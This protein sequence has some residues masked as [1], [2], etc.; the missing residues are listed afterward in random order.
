MNGDGAAAR[1]GGATRGFRDFVR[2]GHR[3]LG[4]LFGGPPPPRSAGAEPAMRAVLAAA[5]QRLRYDPA[6]GRRDFDDLER[7]VADAAGGPVTLN[8]ING[9]CVLVS[10]LRAGGFGADEVWVAL[11]GETSP[12]AASTGPEFHA[13]V[14]LLL[15]DGLLWIDPGKLEPVRSTGERVLERYR[16]YALFN[17]CYVHFLECEKRRLLCAA[18]CGARP[19]AYLFGLAA[20]VLVEALADPAFRALLQAMGS[21]AGADPTDLDDAAR[22]RLAAWIDAGLVA[23]VDGRL[24]PGRTVLLVPWEAEREVF[25]LT[26]CEIDRYLGIVTATLPALRRAFESSTTARRWSWEEVAHAVVAGMLMDLSVGREFRILNRVHAARGESV[27]WAFGNVSA[28]HGVGVAWAE[29]SSGDWGAGQLWHLAARRPAIRL[30]P[31]MVEVLGRLALGEPVARPSAELLY[32]RHRR[33]IG[34]Q[35]RG[36]EVRWPTFL[37]GDTRLLSAVLWAAGRRLLR[38]AILPAIDRLADHPWWCRQKSD[39]SYRHALL[40]LALDYGTDRVFDAGLLSPPPVGEPPPAWGR[41][42]WLGVRGDALPRR[43]DA[44]SASARRQEVAR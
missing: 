35:E 12:I 13:W 33:L 16:L 9:A 38:E 30:S 11:G 18:R 40:R 43:R 29:S 5:R 23:S 32:L 42:L 41:W 20:P 37:P 7:E 28:T 6:P 25:S 39:D 19:R 3:V 10:Y 27:V 21:A 14:V 24:T 15:D 34:Q 26:G 44:E 4:E 17:D 1:Q 31:T 22:A 2:P 36:C 8:C